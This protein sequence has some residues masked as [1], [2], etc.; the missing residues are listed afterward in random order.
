MKKIKTRKNSLKIHFDG[1]VEELASLKKKKELI[2]KR[3][4]IVMIVLS[5]T[6]VFVLGFRLAVIQ[7][8]RHQYYADKLLNYQTTNLIE[9]VPRGRIYDRNGELI[10]ANRPSIALVYRHTRNYSLEDRMKAALFIVENVDFNIDNL[11]LRDKKDCFIL[12]FPDVVK[13]LITT[14]ELEINLSNHTAY[15]QLQLSKITEELISTYFDE[16]TLKVAYISLLMNQATRLYPKTLVIN[17]SPE[18]ASILAENINIL[19]GCSIETQWEREYQKGNTARSIL[20]SISSTSQGIP[21]NS[22]LNY[23]AFGY[24]LNDKVGISGLEAQYEMILSGEKKSYLIEYDEL[25]N[26]IKIDINEGKKGADLVLSID[27]EIQEYLS[28]RVEDELMKLINSSSNIDRLFITIMDPHTGDIIAMVGKQYNHSTGTMYDYSEGNY[29]SAQ[30][31]GSTIKG[32]IIYAGFK[33]NVLTPGEFIY[34]Q[35]WH[36]GDGLTK[37][38]YQDLGLLNDIDALAKSS[39]VYMY[40]IATRLGEGFYAPNNYNVDVSLGFKRLRT[41]ISELGL[42]VKTG[43]DL[44]I[45]EIGY[46]GTGDLAGFLLDAASGQYDTYT[47]LQMAQYVSSIANG[48]KRIRPRI[49]THATQNIDGKDVIVY[50]NPVDV[51]DDLSEFEEAFSRIKAGFRKVVTA[52]TATSLNNSNYQIA[53]KTGTAETS[54][55]DNIALVAYAPYDNP[56]VAYACIAPKAERTSACQDLALEAIQLYLDKYGE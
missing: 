16:K 19:R 43:I 44:P 56:R 38:S 14:E 21:M 35:R 18:E 48:G 55:G 42:G 30:T 41:A 4:L 54:E 29:L 23:L 28:K 32:G 47:T 22:A 46:K 5:I 1:Y 10:V 3:R 27:W 37:G 45:E 17:L 6:L 15:Y 9:A 52:G 20:G 53:A 24:S 49:V 40:T 25:G 26:P 31:I 33:H 11:T 8:S 34:D 36:F 7:F 50:I 2:M 39:N 51:L 13:D 12:L